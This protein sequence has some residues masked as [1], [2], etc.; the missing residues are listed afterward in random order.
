MKN[1]TRLFFGRAWLVGGAAALVLALSAIPALTLWLGDARL[2]AQPHERT[3]QTGVLALA[4]D[5]V[6]LTRILKKYSQRHQLQGYRAAELY[7]DG[8]GYVA[9]NILADCLDALCAAGALPAEW[10]DYCASRLGDAVFLSEDSL[11]F[12]H[13]IA[14]NTDAYAE[15]YACYV[16]GVTV[17]RESQK[18]VALW[19]S[20][21]REL[22]LPQAEAA[23]TLEAYRAYLGLEGFGEWADPA[24]TRFEGVGL[25]SPHAELMLFCETGTY[26]TNDYRAYSQFD[27]TPWN[28]TF[29]RSYFCLNAISVPAKTVSEWQAYARS[30]PEGTPLWGRGDEENSKQ[31]FEEEV[32]FEGALG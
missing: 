4:S 23:P 20:A 17:E 5:D 14:Y 15:D 31:S 25:Y 13:Y 12:V 32:L 27:G 2:L 9:P 28:R 7:P 10:R 24:D 6:Y 30:F 21:P 11:G 8:A 16:V 1:R 18:A 3:R 26:R 29:E 22:D 19:A